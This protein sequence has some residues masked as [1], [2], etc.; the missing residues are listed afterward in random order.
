MM[1]YY[2]TKIPND[3]VVKRLII[4]FMR[5]GRKP[6]RYVR[7]LA[8]TCKYNDIDLMYFSPRDV[9]IENNSIKGQFLIENKWMTKNVP[10][11]AFIDTTPYSFK[12]SKV[13]EFLKENSKLSTDKIGSKDEIYNKIRE[14][15]EFTNLLIPT[16]NNENFSEF[17]DFL[18]KYGTIIVKPKS[19]LRG[20][21]IYMVKQLR[22]KKFII[23]YKQNE[24][25]VSSKDLQA[26]YEEHWATGKHIIQKYVASRTKSGDPFDCRI[27]LEKNGKGKWSVAIYLIRIGSNQKVVSNVAQG[28]SV[29]RLKPFLEANFPEHKDRLEENIKQI[30]KTLPYKFETMFDA[31]FSSLGL[32][33]GIDQD[34]NLYLFE[35]ENGPGTEFG[36][37]Q[38]AS[39]KSEYYKYI[40]DKL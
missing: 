31:P 7:L 8:K 35:V 20:H 25:K 33:I 21:N 15:G 11:P 27:R 13:I 10:V 24:D 18:Q 38:I 19:G 23:S 9:D 39:I 36:E 37:G 2:F 3:K 34:A 17:K 22:R 1:N 5:N 26:F 32:D 12:N 16:G 28:G 14:D 6:F 30:A 4:G 40:S 29:S